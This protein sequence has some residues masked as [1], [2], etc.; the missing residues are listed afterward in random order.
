MSH[1]LSRRLFL[2]GLGGT[3][4]ALPVLET[5]LDQHGE[6]FAQDGMPIPKRYV[7]CFGG[8]TLG[9]DNTNI[10]SA[11]SCRLFSLNCSSKARAYAAFCC[12]FALACSSP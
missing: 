12:C 5:M 2:T 11:S 1:K 10:P 4:M 6:V 3:A 9:G 7:V 8:H